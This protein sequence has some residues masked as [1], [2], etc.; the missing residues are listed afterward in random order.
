MQKSLIITLI[1]SIIV[2]IFAINNSAIVTIDLIFTQIEISEAIVIFVCV[3]IGV[4]ITSIF[5]WVREMKL[6]K[7]IK[8][9][10]L[11]IDELNANIINLEKIVEEKEEQIKLLYSKNEN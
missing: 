5:S 4:A 8:Q 3:L 1:L 10:N 9:L 7:Q 2:I 11:K 6:K